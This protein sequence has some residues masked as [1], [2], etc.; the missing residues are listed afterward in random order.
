MVD[1]LVPHHCCF[2]EKRGLIL[3]NSCK[4]DIISEIDGRCIGCLTPTHSGRVCRSCRLPFSHVW[5]VGARDDALRLL[6]DQKFFGNRAA[7]D[8]WSELI[9][10]ALPQL[11]SATRIVAVPTIRRHIRQR[12]FDHAARLARGIASR[13]GLELETPVVRLDNAVQHGATRRERLVQA[14][15][16]FALGGTITPA[17]PYLIVDDIYT[18]G[19]TVGAIATL[20]RAAGAEDVW[21]AIVARQTEK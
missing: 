15:R 4:N 13:R 19:A 5:F 10:A 8:A 7:I 18:T 2:C 21:V 1:L 20:L 12:G 3:C 14:G 11:P 9:D 17:V 16:S 6:T